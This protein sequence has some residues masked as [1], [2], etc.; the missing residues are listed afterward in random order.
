MPSAM[1]LNDHVVAVDVGASTISAGLVCAGD[2]AV[3][4]DVQ[5]PATGGNALDTITRLIDHVLAVAERRRLQVS[6][7]GIGLPGVIDVEKGALR[8]TPGAW[9]PELDGVPLPSVLGQ[10]TGQRVF[11]DNDVNRERARARGGAR[12]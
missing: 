12:R 4:E 6:G 1:V 5:A 3:V 11:V 2:G 8:W 10:R 9:L 7:I